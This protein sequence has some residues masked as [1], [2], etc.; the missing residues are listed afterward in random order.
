MPCVPTSLDAKKEPAKED[1]WAA[2][3]GGALA[4]Q[5]M[6]AVLCQEWGSW[7]RS[8]FL[9][10]AIL[11]FL[12]AP[13]AW[14][15]YLLFVYKSKRERVISYASLLASTPWLYMAENLVF[16]LFQEMRA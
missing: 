8:F 15:I 1:S 7:P 3:L 12:L 9:L 5:F 10:G 6:A 13:F 11:F 4:M 16:E 2:F 14:S